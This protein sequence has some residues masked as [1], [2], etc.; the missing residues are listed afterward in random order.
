MSGTIKKLRHDKILKKY[1]V[2]LLGL[3][4]VLGLVI[5]P[6]E[7]NGQIKSVAD[8][9]WWAIT[10]VTGVGYGELV[11]VT[12]GGRLIG[13]VLMTVG[14]V[15]FSLVIVILSTEVIRREER[16][17]NRRMKKDLESVN[18][19]LYRVERKL[20]YLIKGGVALHSRQRNGQAQGKDLKV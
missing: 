19:K 3:S 10:T 1:V 12:L 7:K 6:F 8:G 9:L 20:E 14:V 4:L 16:Y 17:W 2:G 18:N 5:V 15:L 13:A 11:P